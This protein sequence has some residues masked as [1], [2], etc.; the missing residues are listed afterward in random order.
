MRHFSRE[1]L[2]KYNDE[3]G[4]IIELIN[5]KRKYNIYQFS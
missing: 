1:K 5:T 2:D 3:K 4:K